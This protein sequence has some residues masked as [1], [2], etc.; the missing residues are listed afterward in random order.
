MLVVGN[1][2]KN[3]AMKNSTSLI[4]LLLFLYGNVAYANTILEKKLKSSSKESSQKYMISSRQQLDPTAQQNDADEL[5]HSVEFEVFKINEDSVSHTTFKSNAG[6]CYGFKEGNGVQVTDASTY[7]MV[8]NSHDEYYLNI[9]DAE[10]AQGKHPKAMKYVPIFNIH[11]QDILK[12][13]KDEDKKLGNK[14]AE[15]NI[16]ERSKVL[17]NVICK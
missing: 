1:K 3:K 2:M 16:E 14:I 9:A 13:V 17:S 8:K 11:D 5:G 10:V 6:I 4:G 7:Y 15:T 12:K